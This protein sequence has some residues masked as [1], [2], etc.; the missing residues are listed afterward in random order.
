[1]ARYG[2]FTELAE[3]ERYCT[4]CRKDLNGHAFRWLELDQRIDAYHDFG[5]VPPEKSQGLFPFGL[6]CAKKLVKIAD[7][8]RIRLAYRSNKEDAA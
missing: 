3:S 6:T 1:M 4:C 2:K 7:V 5:D 8:Q